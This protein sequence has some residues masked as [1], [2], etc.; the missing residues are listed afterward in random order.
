[1]RH[2][3]VVAE[4]LEGGCRR[5]IAQRPERGRVGQNGQGRSR[6]GFGISAVDHE[7]GLIGRDHF[8]MRRGV[9]GQDHAA[10]RHRLEERSR[11]RVGPAWCEMQITRGQDFGHDRRRGLIQQPQAVAI[12][13]RLR[14][15][16][17]GKVVFVV[18]LDV[19]AARHDRIA[20]HHAKHII[21]GFQKSVCN[22]QEPVEAAQAVD[23]PRHE[24]DDLCVV[25]NRAAGD[26]PRSGAAGVPG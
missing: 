18:K 5:R 26:R 3:H 13:R 6:H 12:S 8:P 16:E 20:G 10:G 15:G 23:G 22:R 11:H 25:G 9:G 14:L 2:A 19:Q 4:L 24:S 17:V 21:A 7:P 1:M